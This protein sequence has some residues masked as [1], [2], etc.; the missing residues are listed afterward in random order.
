MLKVEF[1]DTTDERGYQ[2]T[3]VKING[4][5]DDLSYYY[6]DDDDKTS[7]WLTKKETVQCVKNEDFDETGNHFFVCI[8]EEIIDGWQ[9]PLVVNVHCKD[10]EQN[11]F[12]SVQIS[13]GI[14]PGG[15]A[16]GWSVSAFAEKFQ[17]NINQLGN[18]RIRY[19]QDGGIH[20]CNF[21]F[22]HGLTDM[23]VII[24]EAVN[25][26]FD[27]ALSLIKA[28]DNQL[29]ST[30]DQDSVLQYFQFPQETKT[31][32]RQYLIYFT[33][34]LAD[35]D[36]SVET[37]IIEQ[38]GKTLFKITPSD[39]TQA[40]DLIR[41]ALNVYL[42]A[43]GNKEFQDMTDNHNIAIQQ[44]QSNVFHLQSQLLLAKST[45][46]AN[47]AT[48][49]ILQLSNFRYRELFESGKQSLEGKDR[50]S[51]IKDI[52]DIKKFDGK[53]FSINFPEILRKLKRNFK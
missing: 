43:P 6:E 38:A 52:V 33:Q 46:Q 15:W 26:T 1:F 10:H 49:E 29:R 25:N 39:K 21:G 45:Y 17:E 35:L 37:D 5:V 30:I 13:L 11:V 27:I 28:T 32:C 36:I 40:L 51:V 3:S 7:V 23:S 2:N 50:E 20:N 22:I 41:E 48:I 53:W 9:F 8:W 12:P 34:F 18:N 14:N 4:H 24:G 19:F 42:N 47:Q 16:K 44:W 31:A